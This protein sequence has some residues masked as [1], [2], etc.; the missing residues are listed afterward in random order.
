MR[1][2]K[3]PRELAIAMISRSR[4]AVQV[5]AVLADRMGIFAWG[6]NHIGFDGMGCHAEE[7]CFRRANRKRVAGATLYVAAVRRRNGKV[8]TARPCERCQQ[9]VRKC[10]M[11]V[12]RDA[13]GRWVMM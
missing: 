11:V 8:I 13:D 2:P 6:A 5:G 3:D 12:W 4:C 10:G 9:I 1:K 7:E